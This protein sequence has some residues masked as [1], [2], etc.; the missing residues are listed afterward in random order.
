MGIQVDFRILAAIYK[1]T[2]SINVQ[3]SLW[4]SDIDPAGC[5]PG[6]GRA[7]STAI[8]TLY[9]TLLSPPMCTVLC[10][11]HYWPRQTLKGL[12]MT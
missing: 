12:D 8:L 11:L 3:Q 4:Y 7:G 10:E 9:E 2:I 5:V 6:E 1:A